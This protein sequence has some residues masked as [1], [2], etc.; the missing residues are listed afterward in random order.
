ML[1][2]SPTRQPCRRRNHKAR[3]DRLA[4]HQPQLFMLEPRVLHR[5]IEQ[6][7]QGL[8]NRS[9]WRFIAITKL[10]IERKRRHQHHRP[11]DLAVACRESPQLV[12]RFVVTRLTQQIHARQFKRVIVQ[13]PA[14]HR[15]KTNL[16]TPNLRLTNLLLDPAAYRTDLNLNHFRIS[17]NLTEHRLHK[18][19]RHQPPP[20][21]TR[22]RIRRVH[23]H[24]RTQ[25]NRHRASCLRPLDQPHPRFAIETCKV[26]TN[27][28]I[29]IKFISLSRCRFATQPKANPV[30]VGAH[31]VV[32]D[33]TARR[34]WNPINQT[35]QIRHRQVHR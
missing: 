19:L 32:I 26:E 2:L 8:R 10:S 22:V 17:L 27:H 7:R 6:H 4:Q 25:S 12:R 3:V 35:P 21:P 33:P 23:H 1:A 31:L 18:L 24:H 11:V 15:R 20:A 16:P 9:R 5:H 30:G 34:K 14:I 29:A 28:P 13:H